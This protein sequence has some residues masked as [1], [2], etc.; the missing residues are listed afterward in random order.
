MD[1]EKP[2]RDAT[3][4]DGEL[5][6]LQIKL[7]R[8]IWDEI[9][10]Q[11]PGGYGNWP[12]WD[13]VERM[14]DREAPEI[15]SSSYLEIYRSLPKIGPATNDGRR[16]GLVWDSDFHEEPTADSTV[17][18]SL[19]GIIRLTEVE[20]INPNVV[21]AI[22]SVVAM[23]ANWE[24][25]LTPDSTKAAEEQVQLDMFTSG[26]LSMSTFEKPTALSDAVTS[27]I[28]NHEYNCPFSFWELDTKWVTTLRG[29]RLR[30]YRDLKDAHDYL[31]VISKIE[32]RRLEAAVKPEMNGATVPAVITT[33]PTIFIVHGHDD[34][35]KY[36]VTRVVQ[37]LTGIEPTILHEQAN[38]GQTVLEKFETHAARAAAAIVLLTPDDQGSK[39]GASESK[40]RARQNVVF[41]LGYFFGR[42]DRGKV[43]AI[44][45]GN[46]ELPSDLSGLVY[47]DRGT[48]GWELQLAR[49]L[50]R[51]E[52]ISVDRNNLK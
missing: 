11:G 3:V 1:I 30:P 35:A 9:S 51:I 12:T 47:I 48:G 20:Q 45:E 46:V 7:L 41:E 49:E 25:G 31:E 33:V 32:G 28:L 15:N 13:Y 10:R 27:Q 34:A 23:L 14:L 42:L 6:P 29:S 24:K 37:Q 44:T 39:S 22:V 38:E 40:P 5:T 16:Y 52:G 26:Q 19:A 8:I 2:P 4:L 43:I 21:E 50:E 36:H 18:L 17:G